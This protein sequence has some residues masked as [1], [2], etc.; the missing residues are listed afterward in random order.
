MVERAQKDAKGV[1][2]MPKGLRSSLALLFLALA[3]YGCVTTLKAYEPASSVETVIKSVL[4][5]YEN[6]WN[7]HDVYGVL[8]LWHDEA[9]I[10][11]GSDRQ[12]ASKKEYAG[13]LPGRMDSTPSIE[14]KDPHIVLVGDKAVVKLRMDARKFVTPVQFNLAEENGKWEIM[15]WKY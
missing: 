10:M 6:A 12:T 15:S 13:I 8:A 4:V 7:Q 14:L 11:Y 5:S 1:F 9:E 3:F 2:I